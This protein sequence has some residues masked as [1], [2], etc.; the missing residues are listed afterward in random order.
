MAITRFQNV[1]GNERIWAAEASTV[2]MAMTREFLLNTSPTYPPFCGLRDVVPDGLCAILCTISSALYHDWNSL[3][4]SPVSS[5]TAEL[6][7]IAEELHGVI[8]HRY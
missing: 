3:L 5:T 1:V 2:V 4:D 7:V 6:F 8:D